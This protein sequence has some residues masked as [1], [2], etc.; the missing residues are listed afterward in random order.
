MSKLFR[1]KAEL[2]L[3]HL[4]RAWSSELVESGA[5]PRRCEHDLIHLLQEDI[6]NGRMDDSGPLRNGKR[7]GCVAL[8]R[9]SAG[10]WSVSSESSA[11]GDPPMGPSAWP[12]G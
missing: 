7:L 5:D 6:I 4:A 12:T 2:T 3:A 10:T 1:T 11:N 9:W 8:G